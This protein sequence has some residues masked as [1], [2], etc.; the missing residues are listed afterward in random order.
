MQGEKKK[1]VKYASKSVCVREKG[2]QQASKQASI[3]AQLRQKNT[4][5]PWR[6]AE[7][8]KGQRSREKK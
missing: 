5:K 3:R 2:R 7:V 8:Q 6:T 4:T 1:T